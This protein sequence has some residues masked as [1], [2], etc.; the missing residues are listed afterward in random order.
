MTNRTKTIKIAVP[1]V[2]EVDP[3]AWGLSYG[4]CD[5]VAELRE[6]VTEYT[7]NQITVS[8]AAYEGAVTG[9]RLRARK[10]A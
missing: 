1:L 4:N 9:V 5:T 2:L 10:A 8:A 6:A 7:L 3:E